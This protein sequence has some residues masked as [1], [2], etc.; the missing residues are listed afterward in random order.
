MKVFCQST[1]PASDSCRA[2]TAEGDSVQK[3]RREVAHS[4]EKTRMTQLVP[5]LM[6]VVTD[7]VFGAGFAGGYAENLEFEWAGAQALRSKRL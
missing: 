4:E 3:S 6:T 7:R 1:T 2:W 5:K